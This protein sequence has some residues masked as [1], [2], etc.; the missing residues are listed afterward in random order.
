MKVCMVYPYEFPGL[1]R[2]EGSRSRLFSFCDGLVA[3]GVEVHVL[4]KLDRNY[5]GTRFRGARLHALRDFPYTRTGRAA[6][7][8]MVGE[9][10]WELQKE[11]GF[12]V[13]HLHLPNTAASAA[14]WR[15]LIGSR[16]LF[17]THDWFKL[18]DELYFN[19][20]QLPLSLRGTVD[21]AERV[22]AWRHDAIAVTTP[23]LSGVLGR[24]RKT[25]VVPNTVDTGHFK[26]GASK[27]REEHFGEKPVIAFVGFVSIHQGLFE[28]M[29]A[30]KLASKKFKDVRLLV[31]GGGFV[32]RAK[33]FAASL[34][35]SDKVHFT[36]PG[37][38][39]YDEVP[40]LINAADV[41]VSPKQIPPRWHQYAQ[42]LKVL[43]YLACGRPTVVTPLREQRRL[44][45]ESGGGLVAEGFGAEQLAG[46]IVKLLGARSAAMGRAAR[47]YAV[48]RHSQPVVMDALTATYS[49]L[50]G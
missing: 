8:L 41:A 50:V 10:I 49:S 26:P 11:H 9:R 46:A 36:G 14:A 25:F 34:G 30:L 5:V 22:V 20:P 28:L 42:P 7:F 1:D 15:P 35:V 19:I 3:R 6:S 13:V 44:I 39:P 31:I 40:D 16:T 43:E 12:D 33:A 32:E 2:W 21:R 18:E 4:G 48:K 27:F 23:L 17:D 45:A 47:D 38:V 24:G 29:G 37:R